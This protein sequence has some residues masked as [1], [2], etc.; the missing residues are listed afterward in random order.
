MLIEEIERMIRNVLTDVYGPDLSEAL[1][2]TFESIEVRTP[3]SIEDFSF[4]HYHIFLSVNWDEFEDY[5]NEDSKFV[6]ELL[7]GVGD[8][9]N[10]LFHFRSDAQEKVTEQEY[11]EFVRD[12]LENQTASDI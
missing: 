5:F 7:D 6:C 4:A 3:T 1:E 10:T 9:R 11:I 12:Y 2:E 8:I